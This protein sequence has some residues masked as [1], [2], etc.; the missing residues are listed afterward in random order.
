MISS[1]PLSSDEPDADAIEMFCG[2][3]PRTMSENDLRIVFE[4]YGRVYKLNILR[5]KQ[6]GESK[7][8]CFVTYYMRKD[9][10]E[11]QNV[12]H[13]LLIL[14]GMRHPIQM[15][16][17]DVENRNERK[18]FIGMISKSLHGEDIKEL[19]QP[20]GPIEEC[21]VLRDANN[22]SRG[23]A[24][25]TYQTRQS[26][27]N[28]IRTMHHSCTMESCLS[29]I[30]VRFADTPKDKEMRKMQQKISDN[31][32][33]QVTTHS[34]PISPEITD[35]LASLNLMLFN[36]LCSNPNPYV[37]DLSCGDNNT[38]QLISLSNMVGTNLNFDGQNQIVS[39]HTPSATEWHCAD[40]IEEPIL[41]TLDHLIYPINKAVGEGNE[42]NIGMSLS[43]D[44]S[45]SVR[46]QPQYMMNT[47]DNTSTPT[48][49]FINS[50]INSH[51]WPNITDDDLSLLDGFLSSTTKDIVN[52]S[53]LS[54][55]KYANYETA[56]NL[57]KQQNNNNNSQLVK[58][59]HDD[60]QIVGPLGSNL[61][62]Y[63][64]PSEFADDDLAQIF[65]PFGNIL[66]AKVFID[67]STNRSKCF[68]FVSYDNNYSAHQAIQQMNGFHIGCKRLKVQLKKTRLQ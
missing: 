15:K 64:L 26:A 53:N 1:H 41:H 21:T 37:N 19:F 10:L 14:P 5:D 66:S 36:Q 28:A 68:G 40:R 2:Q 25:V 50:E 47:E 33:R 65:S 44:K 18:I 11:A 6:S 3:I 63:H 54:S 39:P 34:S 59:S 49:I 52:I 58:I 46:H 20:F 51:T 8:C 27:L 22:R 24:F 45:Q 60:K 23:C 42:A 67:K 32:L 43:H 56:T 12:L 7:G 13:N 61:F 17:A 9:A 55:V 35:P 16:P 62:I 31:L 48:N 57:S 4:R 29:P 38:N 30:N